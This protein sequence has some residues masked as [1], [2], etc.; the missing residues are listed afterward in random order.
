MR[1]NIKNKREGN[2]L[3]R[4]RERLPRRLLGPREQENGPPPSRPIILV[5]CNIISICI[6]VIVIIYSICN[7][8][9]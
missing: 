6:I 2:Y 4:D 3:I 1:N 7:S 5:I 8:Q 9:N